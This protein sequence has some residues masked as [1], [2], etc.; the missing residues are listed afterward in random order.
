MG[1]QD[2]I[3]RCH[4]SYSAVL[5][6]H[7]TPYTLC[8]HPNRFYQLFNLSYMARSKESILPS[9]LLKAQVKE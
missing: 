1:E 2:M 9:H 7:H 5:A 4:Y 3:S 8:A 6:C